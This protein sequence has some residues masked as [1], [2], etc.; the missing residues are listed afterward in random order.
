MAW[1]SNIDVVPSHAPPMHPFDSD[2]RRLSILNDGSYVPGE[3]P[4]DAPTLNAREWDRWFLLTL[5]GKQRYDDRKAS[6]EREVL[7]HAIHH[8][9]LTEPNDWLDF[10][11]SKRDDETQHHRTSR[12][13]HP[14]NIYDNMTSVSPSGLATTM[15]DHS[16]PPPLPHHQQ[17]A[18]QTTYSASPPPSLAFDD[19]YP[20]QSSSS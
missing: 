13:E 3:A 1:R 16:Y 17:E 18:H 14:N 10:M 9:P 12:D 15:P 7:W 4:D 11:C 19:G 6:E 20:A 8:D 2:Q 5:L